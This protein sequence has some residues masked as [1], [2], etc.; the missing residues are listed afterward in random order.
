MKKLR[1][2]E[3]CL[4]IAAILIT[5]CTVSIKEMEFQNTDVV[6]AFVAAIAVMLVG[7]LVK[8]GELT[9]TGMLIFVFLASP[10]GSIANMY[11]R[12]LPYDKLIHFA[13]GILLAAVGMVLIRNMIIKSMQKQFPYMEADSVNITTILVPVIF[14]SCMFSGA[15]AGIWEIFEYAADI[16]ITGA[17]QRGMGDTIT[18]MIAGNLGALAYGISMLIYYKLLKKI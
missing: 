13:S 15:A 5:V 9:Y 7:K 11:S 18:D 12:W 3:N 6:G 17:M 4:L 10:I 1:L 2:I 14:A 8:V 16:V